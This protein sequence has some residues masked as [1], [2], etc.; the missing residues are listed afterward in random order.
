MAKGKIR[1]YRIPLDRGG[2]TKSGQYFGTGP[3]LYKAELYDSDGNYVEETQEFR[4]YDRSTASV[5]AK[6]LFNIR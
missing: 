5:K 3:K 2:Y 4:S 1:L 6:T